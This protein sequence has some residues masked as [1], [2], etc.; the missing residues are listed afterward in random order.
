MEEENQTDAVE[1]SENKED[2]IKPSENKEEENEDEKV[3]F[4]MLVPNRTGG[5]LIGK[6]LKLLFYVC[7]LLISKISDS[8]VN[9]ISHTIL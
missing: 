1:S 7:F 8:F 3:E 2:D 6:G 9:F 5:A 4:R